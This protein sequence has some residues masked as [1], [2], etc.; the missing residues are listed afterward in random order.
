MERVD[1]R[2]GDR[3][4]G[5]GQCVEDAEVM[6]ARDAGRP[7]SNALLAAVGRESLCLPLPC[8]RLGVPG[9]ELP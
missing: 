4:A 7:A 9:P 1:E 8:G 3:S 2:A 5:L 6:G